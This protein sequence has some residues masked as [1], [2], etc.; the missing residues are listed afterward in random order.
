M[1]AQ[2]VAVIGLGG[3]GGVVAAALQLAGKH[4]VVACL[5]RP[6]TGLVLHHPGGSA[7]V[8]LRGLTEPA[9]A[10][11]V[12]W[13]V[14]CTKAQDTANAGPWLQRLCG[15]DTRVAVLQNGLGHAERVAPFIGK[16]P[17]VPAVIYFNSE[18]LGPDGVR[19]RRVTDHDIAVPDDAD[20]RAFSALFQG[21]LMDVYPAADFA[22][23]AWRKLLIN[24]V[25]NPLTAI[26]RQRQHVLR[27]EDIRRLG[28]GL[29]EEAVAVGRAD[30]AALVEDEAAAIWALLMT[31]PAEAGTSMYHDTMAGR[32]LE[33][34]ALTGT[35]VA[36]GK[37]HG[38]PT[39]LNAMMLALLGAVSD[40]AGEGRPTPQ[41]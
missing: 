34:E 30:G 25:A 20:G 6:F 37:R 38:I 41:T 33:A 26:T 29:L 28:L 17:V 5:R 35:V 27:R 18:R 14:L 32:P 16:S 24:I 23:R 9:E 3:I 7:E 13:V 12:D 22:T 2:N 11:P 15:P 10:Q 21:S 31:Y 4:R 19:L 40:A 8:P 1:A 39:P 36:G